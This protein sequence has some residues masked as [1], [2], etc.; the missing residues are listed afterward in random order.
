MENVTF[1]GVI[2]SKIDRAEWEE[3]DQDARIELENQLLWE[4]VDLSPIDDDEEPV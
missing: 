4:L 3:M 1:H 2:D